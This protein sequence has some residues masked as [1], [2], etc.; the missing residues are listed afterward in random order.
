MKQIEIQQENIK[1][2]LQLVKESPKLEI[3]PM[4]N[5]ECVGGDEF[6]FLHQCGD[7]CGACRF[8]K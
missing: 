3:V 6:I 7:E 2:L 4:V 1:Q 8:K 5:S